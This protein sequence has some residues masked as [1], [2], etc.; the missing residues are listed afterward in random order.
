MANLW[1]VKN[2]FKYLEGAH[3][4]RKT[5]KTRGFF[6]KRYRN[7]SVLL[8]VAIVLAGAHSSFAQPAK[9]HA[10]PD[11]DGVVWMKSTEQEKKAFLFGAGSAVVLEY[12]IRAKHSE[13]P[14]KFVAG[15]VEALKD[16]SWTE[17]ANKVDQYYRDN[18]EKLHRHVFEVIWHELIAPNWKS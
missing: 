5:F 6:M 10:A 13:E 18:P 4:A 16:M 15:W 12:H 11:V 17:L 9:T 2:I 1:N 3:K 8:F 7:L 14:S